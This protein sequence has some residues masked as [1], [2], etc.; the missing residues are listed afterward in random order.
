MRHMTSSNNQTHLTTKL[1]RNQTPQES[2][3]WT[4]LRNR[5]FENFKFRRQFKID[6]YIVDF[7]CL[8]NKLIIEIDGGHHNE[9]NNI[10]SDKERQQYLESRGYKVIRFW[11]NEIDRNIDGV[12]ERIS[13]SLKT[14]LP[15]PNPLRDRRGS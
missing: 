10:D 12:I 6:N 15:H 7:C 11:N 14:V 8:N 9:L 1:R 13:D 2:K 5:G 4:I 3:L